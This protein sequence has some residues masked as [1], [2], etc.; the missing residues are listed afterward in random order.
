LWTALPPVDGCRAAVGRAWSGDPRQLAAFELPPPEPA[1]A[2]GA[3]EEVE[4]E[5]ELSFEDEEE[6]SFDEE[7]PSFD[8]DDE[9]P[10]EDEALARLSVR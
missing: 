4:G 3:G 6:F 2:A 8:D 1:G 7:E 5:D 9:A 10:S